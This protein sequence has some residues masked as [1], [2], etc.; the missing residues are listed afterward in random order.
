MG[1]TYTFPIC[2]PQ[3]VNG[4]CLLLT[5]MVWDMGQRE[6]CAHLSSLSM[7]NLEAVGGLGQTRKGVMPRAHL[8]TRG[9]FRMHG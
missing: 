1:V 5:S 6:A 2:Y 3:G 8:I 4:G 9:Y 7:L